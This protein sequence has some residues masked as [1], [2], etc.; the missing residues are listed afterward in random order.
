MNSRVFSKHA[1]LRHH[2]PS[3]APAHRAFSNI[4]LYIYKGF[5]TVFGGPRIQAARRVA[6]PPKG[7]VTSP[8]F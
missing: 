7:W 2:P 6:G 4:D 5:L 1:G 8:H 3:P